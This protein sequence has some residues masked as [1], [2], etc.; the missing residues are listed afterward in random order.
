MS[1]VFDLDAVMA[2]SA[3]EPLR[4][5]YAGREWTLDHIQNFDWR[6]IRG[7]IGGDLEAVVAS[8]RMGMGDEQYAEFDKLKQPVFALDKLFDAWLEHCGLSRGKS[9]D[10][11]DSSESTEKPSKPASRRATRASGSA[12]SRRAR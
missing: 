5:T 11:T 12:T 1:E 9:P 7:G 3:N 2:E 8:M 4:F 10:S 6:V